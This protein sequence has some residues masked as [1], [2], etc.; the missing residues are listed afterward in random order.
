MGGAAADVRRP[1]RHGRPG[2]HL[3]QPPEPQPLRRRAAR[4]GP[5]DRRDH[6]RDEHGGRGREDVAGGRRAG[7]RSTASRCRSPS[8]SYGVVHEGQ[9]GGRGLPGPAAPQPTAPSCTAWARAARGER[10]A[11][12]L[13]RPADGA[14]AHH[15]RHRPP[16]VDVPAAGRDR[17]GRAAQRAAAG[18]RPH[19]VPGPAHPGR[20]AARRRLGVALLARAPARPDA[21]RRSCPAATCRSS[22]TSPHR[23]WTTVGNVD[24]AVGGD[25]RPPRAWSRRWFDGWS[26]DWWIGADDRWHLP[27]REIG[28]APAAR[29]RHAGG[30]D[31]DAH[32]RRR[33][34]RSGSTPCGAARRGRRRAGGRRD[35]ERVAGAGR[36][37]AGRA[38]VQPRGPGGGR[39]HRAAR[40]H[41]RHRRR[42]AGAAAAPARRRG[43]RR[44]RSTTATR[45]P[46][47]IGGDAGRALPGRPVRDP[48]GLAQAAFV[49]PLAHG[50]TFRVASRSA[51]APHPPPGPARR[52]VAAAPTSRRRCRRPRR[53][54]PGWQAQTRPG[55]AARA[56]RRPAGRGGR[57]QPAVPAAAPRRRRDHARARRPTTGSGSATP[58]TCSP[59]STAT[60]TTT[61]CAEVLRLVPRPPARRR[62]L[63]QPAPGVGR[64]RRRPRAP[65]PSTGG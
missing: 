12:W 1:G 35:R 41:D 32:P 48:A 39:A 45:P 37:G 19:G 50:A 59:R 46:R 65:W 47:C 42:P 2:R 64:Q 26:L 56:A 7:R 44:R 8:R 30:R 63:L 28:G 55:H 27:S 34:G 40:R 43:W 38:A 31:G 36:R 17:R 10:P 58:P 53:W 4:Q 15:R 14:A 24:S 25:R 20:R 18:R 57:R 60:A 29:R 13:L 3:H 33:R 21:R 61:R 11:T 51:R 22:P 54:P 5:D 62:L 49:F 6:R 52:R 9:H 23:N 16:P